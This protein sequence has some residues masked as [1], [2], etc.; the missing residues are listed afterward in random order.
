[1]DTVS[2]DEVVYLYALYANLPTGMKP[3][4]GKEEE[5]YNLI[6]NE[7]ISARLFYKSTHNKK[8][9]RNYIEK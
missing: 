8:Y 5:I 6:K 2:S 1:M 3:S 4:E 9:M 7:K